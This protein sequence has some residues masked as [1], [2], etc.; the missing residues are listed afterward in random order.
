MGRSATRISAA[1][2]L[3]PPELRDRRLAADGAG[4]IGGVRLGLIGDRSTTRLSHCYQQVPLRLLPPF[5]FGAGQPCLLYLLNPTAG[6][7]DG[8]GQ[9]VDIV[10]GSGTRAVVVSQ[11]ATRVHPCLQGL[12][13]QQWQIRVEAGAVLVVLPGP[14]IPF[15]GCHYYQ[16]VD[17][18]LAAD[19]GLVWGDIWLA[20]R[21][22]R[23]DTSEQF[24]FASLIQDLTV[25]RDDCLVFRDRFC[26]KGP[27]DRATAEWHF[28]TGPA[29]GSLFVTGPVQEQ[30]LHTMDSAMMA[31]FPTAMGDLCVRWSGNSESVTA[32]V[33]QNALRLAAGLAG[34]SKE[35]P[36]LPP[37]YD[38]A[39][40]HWFS[41]NRIS[42]PPP[43][44]DST[45]KPLRAAPD[46]PRRLTPRK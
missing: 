37:G 7:M 44:S 27:W 15:A 18:S 46:G 36:W 2:F 13:T 32:G 21:Y 22:A 20:G 43:R 41:P 4:R 25:R 28:G 19:A 39:P 16:R 42:P 3:T 40:N 38:L 35:K 34:E 24:Q 6:L 10:A 9:L 45:A 26:W 23:G 12:S 30:E 5:Q 8:D 33:V 29:C 31:T 17:I 14:T 11:S 1:D